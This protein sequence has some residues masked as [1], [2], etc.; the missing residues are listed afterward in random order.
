MA[1]S[2]APNMV[3]DLGEIPE[4]CRGFMSQGRSGY[5]FNQVIK[6]SIV[7]EYHDI[8]NENPLPDL[9]IILARD[10]LSFL[11]LQNQEKVSA[12]FREKLKSRGLVILGRNEAMSGEGWLSVGRDPVSAFVQSE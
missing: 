11:N 2:Q 10:I 1:I 3:F 12:G 9:D 7:F 5:S 6:D 4:Y 8:L